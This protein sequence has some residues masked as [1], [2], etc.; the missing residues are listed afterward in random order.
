VT[1]GWQR[2]VGT[3]G[4]SIGIDRFGESAPGNLVLQNLGMTKDAVLMAVRALG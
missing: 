4:R 2:W 1:M 3:R